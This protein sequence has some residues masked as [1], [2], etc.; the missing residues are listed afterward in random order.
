MGIKI[1]HCLVTE[2]K[3]ADGKSTGLEMALMLISFM[4]LGKV[5]PLASVF[6]TRQ[7]GFVHEHLELTCL[8][9]QR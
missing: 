6:V 2:G 7:E 3:L 8:T 5:L 9:S 1:P 4:T